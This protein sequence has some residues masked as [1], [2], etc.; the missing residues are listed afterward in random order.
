LLH[1]PEETNDLLNLLNEGQLQHDRFTLFDQIVLQTLPDVNLD[2]LKEAND[3][4]AEILKSFDRLES[5]QAQLTELFS[6]LEQ[7][8]GSQP[9]KRELEDLTEEEKKQILENARWQLL[10]QLIKDNS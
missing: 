8:F 2:E 1:R 5:D 4:T 3:F 7:E 9:A 10:D 6:V